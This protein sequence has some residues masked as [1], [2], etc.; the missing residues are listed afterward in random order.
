M[1]VA[2][3]SC[4]FQITNGKIE[5]YPTAA[6]KTKKPSPIVQIYFALQRARPAYFLSEFCPDTI[7]KLL[8]NLSTVFYIIIY[9]FEYYNIY[10][11]S[12]TIFE[13]RIVGWVISF[14]T[15]CSRWL[16]RIKRSNP[17]ATFI[18]EIFDINGN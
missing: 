1:D 2:L 10:L 16:F 11:A 6:I 7:F 8:M 18:K 12:I 14:V 4:H 17:F 13:N 15:F 9:F 3:E 5:T